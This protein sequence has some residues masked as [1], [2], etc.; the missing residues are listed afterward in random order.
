MPCLYQ[1]SE[2]RLFKKV[3]FFRSFLMNECKVDNVDLLLFIMKPVKPIL[4]QFTVV[5]FSVM[6]VT[7]GTS[8][9]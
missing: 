2:F 6:S 3:D 9:S 1:A 7:K 5:V 8:L 4:K